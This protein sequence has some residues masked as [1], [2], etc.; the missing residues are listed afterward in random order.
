MQCD[1]VSC[2]SLSAFLNLKE[3]SSLLKIMLKDFSVIVCF[4]LIPEQL[5]QISCPQAGNTKKTN[6]FC[7]C[8]ETSQDQPQAYCQHHCPVPWEGVYPDFTVIYRR[9]AHAWQWPPATN[10]AFL[11][12]KLIP[13]CSSPMPS[14]QAAVEPFYWELK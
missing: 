3:F 10:T 6:H 7:L 11:A 2:Q 9:P 13:W 14:L 1:P 12:A 5:T 4:F 8:H